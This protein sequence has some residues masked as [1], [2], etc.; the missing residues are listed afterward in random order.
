VKVF[1]NRI[2]V[3]VAAGSAVLIPLGGAAIATAGPAAAKPPGIKCTGLS[4]KVNLT[5][6]SAKIK[7]T[8]C[9]GNTGG[10]GKTKGSESSTT[11]TDKWTN[12]K[13]TSFDDV[14]NS[15]GTAT[16]P[17]G[18]ISELSTATVTS[19]TTGDTK[20]GA[21]ESAN[22]CFNETTDA[23]SLAPGTDYVIKG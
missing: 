1:K 23:L 2:M 21:A 8:G 14:T 15:G 6:D 4:G 10:K 18:D 5:T 13:K 19:D 11:G 12:G 7:L 9:S 20:A 22:V 3:W 17:T 16:C